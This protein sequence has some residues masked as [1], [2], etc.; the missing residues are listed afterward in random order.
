MLTFS[1][2]LGDIAGSASVPLFIFKAAVDFCCI[3]FIFYLFF[4]EIKDSKSVRVTIGFALLALFYLFARIFDLTGIEWLL[5][6]FF[7]YA[8]VLIIVVFRNEI[9]NMLASM[10]ILSLNMKQE[11]YSGEEDIISH[12][13][14][15]MDYLASVREGALV[16]IMP[17]TDAK[18]GAIAEGT[19]ID[20][21]ITRE[22]LLTIFKKNSPL[23][24][25]AVIIKNRRIA[26]ASVFFSLSTNPD[27]DPNFGTRH[28]AAYGIS[29]K[30]PE[31]LVIVVSEERGE[32]SLLHGGRITRDLSKDALKQQLANRL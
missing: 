20:S 4:V 29:E 5:G 3:Y 28:R 8:A 25:G 15:A 18:L 21:L 2:F 7:S 17:S 26:R 22:L 9:K 11:E 32:I 6:N 19:E 24:D 12:I 30:V 14:N 23:H 13:A 16:V 27:I 1:E 10:S 31:A